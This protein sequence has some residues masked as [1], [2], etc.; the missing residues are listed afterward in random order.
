MCPVPE[1][2]W[3]IFPSSG[4]LGMDA[5]EENLDDQIH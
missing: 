2:Y 5:F 1:R 4:K 3:D